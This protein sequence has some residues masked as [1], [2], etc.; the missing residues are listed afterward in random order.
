MLL[1]HLFMENSDK[2]PFEETDHV[3]NPISIYAATK[4]AMN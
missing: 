4:R 1:A 3:D 2:S